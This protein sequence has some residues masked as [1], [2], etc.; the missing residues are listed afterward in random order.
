MRKSGVKPALCY[1]EGYVSNG[2]AILAALMLAFQI[3]P[4]GPGSPNAYVD[5]VP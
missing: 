5:V 3:Q 4:C 1:S 2:A